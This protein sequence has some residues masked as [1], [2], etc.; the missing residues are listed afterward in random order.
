MKRVLES[1][2]ASA[3]VERK[4]IPNGINLELFKP[5]DRTEARR[6]IGVPE[7]A[8]VLLFAANRARVSPFKDYGTVRAAAIEVA[9]TL[10]QRRVLLLAL[11]DSGPDEKVGNTELRFVPY[12][13]EE[14]VGASFY[15]AADIYLHAAH[16]AN[17]TTT[18]LAEAA[19]GPIGRAPFR[20]RGGTHV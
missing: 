20:D 17:F 3:V 1:S 7:D 2:V 8:L 14:A 6:R 18:L 9:R 10:P 11:G 13:S 15:P 16:A 12:Q 5:G 19:S 4:V